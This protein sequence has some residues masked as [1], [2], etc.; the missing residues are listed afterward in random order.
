MRGA[1][2]EAPTKHE[3]GT[4]VVLSW[5]YGIIQGRLKYSPATSYHSRCMEAVAVMPLG[6]DSLLVS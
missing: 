3:G 6:F 2:R 1:Y 5:Y 4:A